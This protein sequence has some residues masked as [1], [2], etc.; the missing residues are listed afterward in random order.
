MNG[1][2]AID[3]REKLGR[4]KMADAATFKADYEAIAVQMKKEIEEV[5]AGGEDA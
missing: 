3:V 2:F 1:L 5:I 4:A